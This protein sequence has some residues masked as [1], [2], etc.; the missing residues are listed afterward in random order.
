[1]HC[2]FATEV[3]S[4]L[5]NC[6]NPLNW[7]HSFVCW[8]EGLQKNSL[9]DNYSDFL[10]KVL[11]IAWE[12]WH[13]R[14]RLVFQEL[15]PSPTQ[16]IYGAAFLGTSFCKANPVLVK[17]NISRSYHIKWK[18]PDDNFLKL[19]FDDSVKS[20]KSTTSCFDFR[21]VHVNRSYIDASKKIGKFEV[22]IAEATALREGLLEL[23]K[24]KYKYSL[25]ELACDSDKRKLHQK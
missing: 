2:S 4:R 22:L 18:P 13:A 17:N 14:N 10:P 15:V 24:F 16:I 19:N 12:I 23:A 20:D 7:N 25:L 8:L 9:Q 6:P 11:L 21:D 1:M 5:P 3:W